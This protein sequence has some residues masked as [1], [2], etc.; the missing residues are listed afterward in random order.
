MSVNIKY[1]PSCGKPLTFICC[2]EKQCFYECDACRVGV[3]HQGTRAIL[4]PLGCSKHEFVRDGVLIDLSTIHQ[5]MEGYQILHCY[6]CKQEIRVERQ[7][8]EVRLVDV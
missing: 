7:E 6:R 8:S 2:W 4:I 5:V 1:C 3:V